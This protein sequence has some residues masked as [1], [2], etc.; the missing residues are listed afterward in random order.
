MKSHCQLM[1][2]D[3]APTSEAILSSGISVVSS[4]EEQLRLVMLHTLFLAA[5]EMK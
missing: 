5:K 4:R 2:Q 3:V 1:N